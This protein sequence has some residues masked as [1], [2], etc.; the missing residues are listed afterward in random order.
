VRV[1][2]VF[3]NYAIVKPSNGKIKHMQT[4]RQGFTL[5]ELL[6]VIGIIAILAVA[7]FVAL[8]PA[9]RFADSRNARRTSDVETILSAVHQYLIDNKGVFPEGFPLLTANSEFMIGTSTSGGCGINQR[10]CYTSSASACADFSNW[11]PK[12]LKE[13]PM[14]P[15]S[16]TQANTY[17]DI[18]MDDH[19]IIT[20]K[21][22]NAEGKD[23]QGNDIVIS[24]SR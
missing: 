12:Y 5:I 7:V 18:V 15:Q 13:M 20:V 8:D 6:L 10:G 3:Q 9:K 22:C 1:F 4:K 16:G 2:F 14:D 19:G 21:A 11:L 23:A 17:Y 24:A